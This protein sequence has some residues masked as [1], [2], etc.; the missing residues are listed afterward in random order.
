MDGF[1]SIKFVDI[2]SVF[3]IV[4]IASLLI[5]VISY[6]ILS[7]GLYSHLLSILTY[8]DFFNKSLEMIAYVAIPILLIWIWNI[9]GRPPAEDGESEE[10]YIKRIGSSDFRERV[11]DHLFGYWSATVIFILSYIF[12]EKAW[13]FI[14]A[15]PFIMRFSVRVII[16]VS[17][18]LRMSPD[19]FDRGAGYFF[20][21]ASVAFVLA[22][23]L[24]FS[25]SWSIS[26]EA[27]EFVDEEKCEQAVVCLSD[28]YLVDGISS[29]YIISRNQIL[30]LYSPESGVTQ[31]SDL[32]LPN[33]SSRICDWFGIFCDEGV[34]DD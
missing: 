34:G 21:H 3:S 10:Q 23:V 12:F 14:G 25:N 11:M 6:W 8:D 17:Q 5:S 28:Y 20:K 13:S 32:E 29:G 18:K 33:R 22:L 26:L 9:T 16:D 1:K 4:S 7:I 30:Y 19:S 24:V 2:L 31:I 15:V 27:R